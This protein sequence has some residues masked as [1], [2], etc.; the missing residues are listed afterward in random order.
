MSLVFASVLAHGAKGDGVT[1]DTAAIQTAVNLGNIVVPAGTYLISDQLSV[2]SNR[3]VR[4]MPAAVFKRKDGTGQQNA[5][6]L[7][8]ANFWMN[9]DPVNGNANIIIEGGIY[10]G[11]QANQTPV[12]YGTNQSRYCGGVGMRFL[13]VDNLVIRDVRMDNNI[14]F[15][16]QIGQVTNFAVERVIFNFSGSG[17]HQDGVHVNGPASLGAI[18]YI[19]SNGGND[20]L[21]ALNADDAIF[22]MMTDGGDITN[23]TVEHVRSTSALSTPYEG[24]AIMLLKGPHNIRDILV[25]DF[26][27]RG[28][29]A[30]TVIDLETFQDVG[31]D[32][33]TITRVVF[34]DFDVGTPRVNDGFCR[35]SQNVGD[36]TFHNCRWYPGTGS[37]DIVPSQQSFF[38]Q[39]TGT[40]GNLVFDGIQIIGHNQHVP[41]FKI[42][43][44]RD[45]IMNNILLTRPGAATGVYLL[46]T[47]AGGGTILNLLI[48]G[49]IVENMT[50][51]VNGGAVGQNVTTG[52]LLN[53]ASP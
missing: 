26:H 42:T 22:G 29:Q 19:T 3:W 27:G 37:A 6:T 9:S 12:D 1:D 39:V 16:F 30:D 43:T 31:A 20:S 11:N 47:S 35:L 48:N 44:A 33:G 49:A 2:P 32:T 23:I 52:I 24:S 46:D 7:T 18:R 40:A 14:S 10:D 34:E 15:Q 5:T 8:N 50:G 13:N 53:P 45:V 38:E 28:F 17:L 36:L 21:V 51:L 4:L 41:P 25:R